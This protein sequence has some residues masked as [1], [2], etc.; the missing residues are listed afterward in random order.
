[1]NYR[2]IKS[3]AR[4]SYSDDF[5]AETFS[6]LQS[7]I[8]SLQ[9]DLEETQ[10]KSA[11]PSL[12]ESIG[13]FFSQWSLLELQLFTLADKT[14]LKVTERSSISKVVKELQSLNI[15]QTD[16]VDK[17]NKLRTFRNQLVH[18]YGKL[19]EITEEQI[20][21]HIK[22]LNTLSNNLAELISKG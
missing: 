4:N 3:D 16:F 11:S 5:A 22:E 8:N 13:E 9:R 17:L 15:L 2:N 19:G 10:S 6:Q 12:Y 21:T 7:Q 14:D 20:N 18:P 1:M